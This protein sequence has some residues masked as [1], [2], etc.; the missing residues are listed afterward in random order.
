M[1]LPILNACRVSILSHHYRL[2]SRG[3]SCFVRPLEYLFLNLNT[4][5]A[6][7]KRKLGPPNLISNVNSI[8]S[9]GGRACTPV[10]R[11][12]A[13]SSGPSTRTVPPSRSIPRKSTWTT[14]RALMLAAFTGV[15]VYAGTTQFPGLWDSAAGSIGKFSK[16]TPRYAS[17]K[18]MQIVR[19]LV[20][21]VEQPEEADC[22]AV[23]P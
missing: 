6:A 19:L 3:C 23:G 14:S 22:S 4:M 20:L 16:G 13:S 5:F 18:D 21:G 10:Q 7:A 9:A 8:Q 17:L 12:F 1:D 15:S 2:L 11:K